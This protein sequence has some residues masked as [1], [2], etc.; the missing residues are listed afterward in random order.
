MHDSPPRLRPPQFRLRTLLL[1]VAAWAA[2]FAASHWLQPV[3]VA[4]LVLLALSIVAHVAGNAIGTRLRELG[5]LKD[6]RA[7]DLKPEARGEPRFAPVTR[8]GLKQS[9]GWP[10]VIATAAGIVLGGLGGGLWTLAASR[11]PIEPAAAALGA[12]AFAAL[13]GI[14]AFATVGFTQALTGAI[15]Q[16]MRQSAADDKPRH[17]EIPVRKQF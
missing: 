15:W 2:I 10:L 8:L 16:A 4:A 12:I 1:L 6:N 14:A 7:F 3:W 9:L 17:S 13:G 5:S 11:G